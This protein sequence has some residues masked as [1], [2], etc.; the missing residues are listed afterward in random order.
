MA[1]YAKQKDTCLMPNSD[2]SRGGHGRPGP[3][4]VRD[5]I[6]SI[7]R[8]VDLSDPITPRDLPEQAAGTTL[9]SPGSFR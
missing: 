3:A 1:Q 8:R 2:R 4:A 9:S 5:D 6:A 7:R